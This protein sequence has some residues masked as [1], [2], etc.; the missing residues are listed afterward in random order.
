[1]S[2]SEPEKTYWAAALNTT[3]GHRD[4]ALFAARM[5]PQGSKERARKVRVARSWN[6]Q[7]RMWSK[8]VRTG[9]D[10]Y[11]PPPYD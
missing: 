7:V 10:P 1:M 2:E 4:R 9:E 5:L 6:E 11:P 8:A 3:R